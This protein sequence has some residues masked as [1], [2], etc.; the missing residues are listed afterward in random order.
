[1]PLPQRVSQPTR[2]TLATQF[3]T[4]YGDGPSAQVLADISADR[5]RLPRFMVRS[6]LRKVSDLYTP[7]AATL[8]GDVVRGVTPIADGA[9][10]TITETVAGVPKSLTY[11]FVNTGNT[12]FTIDDFVAGAQTNCTVSIDAVWLVGQPS[13]GV[14]GGIVATSE[15]AES[16]VV[17]PVSGTLNVDVTVTPTA[18]GA[19]SFTLSTPTNVVAKNPYNW[20]VDGTAVAAAPEMD[21]LV[22]VNPLAN[23]GTD[24]VAGTIEGIDTVHSYI[25]DNTGG[26]PLTLA[27]PVL[28]NFVNC[29]AVVSTPLTSPVAEFGTTGFSVTVTPTAAGAWSYTV[30]VANN[31]SDENPYDWTVD[32]VAAVAASEMDVLVGVAPLASGGT[33]TVLGTTNG[34]LT[35]Q[36]YTINNTGNVDLTFAAAVISNLVNCTA[37][38]ST[39]AVSPIAAAG[40]DDLIIDITPTAAGAW[41]FDVSIANNDADENPYTWTTDGV[42]A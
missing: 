32:G 42:A 27:A 33:D 35:P 28:D 19:W 36:T 12:L 38:V 41:S 29:T 39:P 40:T 4:N 18:A 13:I 16:P 25:I 37:V 21:V 24:T 5:Q 9:T 3:S 34:V 17:A 8:D 1:M 22:G 7:A 30:S 11:S 26:L 14:D 31:D 15:S 10:D 6:Q 2:D 23:G 20:T